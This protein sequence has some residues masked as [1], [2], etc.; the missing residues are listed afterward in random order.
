VRCGYCCS[1]KNWRI[2]LPYFD[3]IKLRENYSKYIEDSR[4]SHFNKRLKIGKRG[5][6]L[7]TDDNLCRI[8]IEKGYSYKPTMCK[9]FPFS[10]RVKWN[11]DFLLIIKHY[12]KGIRVGE[13]SREVINH[14]IECCEE[15]YLDQLERIRLIGM[16]TS[17][18]CKL[19]ERE[20]ITWEERE[21]FG[22]YIFSSPNLDELCRRCMEVVNL[23]VSKDITYI[24]K[25]IEGNI[26]KS[27]NNCNYNYFINSSVK[28]TSK[29]KKYIEINRFRF[30]ER[31]IIR[32]LGELNKR[33]IFRK[34]SFKEELYRLIIIGKK[35][36]RYKNIFEG[37]GVIDLKLTIN[38]SLY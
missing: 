9:L 34:L 28:Y 26:T 6:I 5:C 16:E 37:E 13:C 32:Y 20:Y 4:R 1:C 15:L 14:A 30:I 8:Q 36:S 3:Y 27:Y 23:N 12:C 2:Y 33:E 11:G 18:R 17:T 38:E 10:F 21:E 22:R 7:L 31:E 35:L 25:N 24:K 19:D 29:K